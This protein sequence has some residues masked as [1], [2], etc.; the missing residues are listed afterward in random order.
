MTK[1]VPRTTSV[2]LNVTDL[3][4]I[5]LGISAVQDELPENVRKDVS[6][7]NKR[8][9]RAV[10]RLLDLGHLSVESHE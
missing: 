5:S 8:L 7:L 6:R 1:K 2:K 9:E 10:D 3:A 4:V